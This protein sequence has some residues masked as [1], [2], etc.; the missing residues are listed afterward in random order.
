MTQ[1][2]ADAAEVLRAR[3]GALL[4][5]APADG[6]PDGEVCAAIDAAAER[7]RGPRAAGQ[8]HLFPS[9]STGLW[10][11]PFAPMVGD[12]AAAFIPGDA[13][14]ASADGKPCPPEALRHA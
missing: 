14:P 4:T 12:P 9:A 10:A 8:L 6:D 11:V 2:V 7:L 1:A 3:Y 5:R 13:D